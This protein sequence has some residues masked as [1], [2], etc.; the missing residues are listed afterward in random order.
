MAV[1]IEPRD[2]Q[3]FRVIARRWRRR[4]LVDRGA[5]PAFGRHQRP[6]LIAQIVDRLEQGQRLWCERNESG[7]IAWASRNGRWGNG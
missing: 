3:R 6:D 1:S 7:I 4:I 5:A 2:I